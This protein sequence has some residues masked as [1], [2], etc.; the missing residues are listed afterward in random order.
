VLYSWMHDHSEH[1]EKTRTILRQSARLVVGLLRLSS[2]PG[3]RHFRRQ[4]ISISHLV[5]CNLPDSV[6]VEERDA[7]T[8][9]PARTH[10]GDE[11][12]FPAD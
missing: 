2:S 7:R 9:D 3:V 11:S 4:I 1:Q 5:R 8:D 10:G 12:A 6:K